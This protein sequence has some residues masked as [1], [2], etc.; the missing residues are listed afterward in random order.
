MEFSRRARMRTRKLAEYTSAE[1]VAAIER[2][3][4]SF[5]HASPTHDQ[6]GDLADA[7]DSLGDGDFGLAVALARAAA[8]SRRVIDKRRPP[9]KVP[10]LDEMRADFAKLRTEAQGA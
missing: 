6:I 1:A 8:R 5:E 2:A 7:I 3:F 4:A 9:E 10:T